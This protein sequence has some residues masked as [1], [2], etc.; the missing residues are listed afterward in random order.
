MQRLP[1]SGIR[2]IALEFMWAGPLNTLML[3]N[4]GAEVIK[5]EYHQA[6][7]PAAEAGKPALLLRAHADGE[8]GRHPYLRG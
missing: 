8:T 3:A 1:L 6:R 2:V 5:V 4:L 7:G